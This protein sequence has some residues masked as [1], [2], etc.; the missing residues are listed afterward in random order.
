MAS[1][2]FFRREH[3]CLGRGFD[4][5]E[6]APLA[7]LCLPNKLSSRTPLI[8]RGEP[9]RMADETQPV[10][11]NAFGLS[12]LSR[13]NFDPEA[14][15]NIIESK[16]V[17][18]RLLRSLKRSRPGVLCQFECVIDSPKYGPLCEA[19]FRRSAIFRKILIPSIKYA[20][21]FLMHR[22]PSQVYSLLIFCLLHTA[23]VH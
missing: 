5:P 10:V 14:W 18:T 2:S 1:H 20:V 6:T 3:T 19:K 8:N 22:I 15:K 23:C 21:T 12:G 17:C 11:T 13:A 4:L 7:F 16:P 9:V